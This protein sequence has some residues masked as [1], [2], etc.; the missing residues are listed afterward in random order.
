MESTCG[1]TRGRRGPDNPRGHGPEE[2]ARNP[3][4]QGHMMLVGTALVDRLVV[5]EELSRFERLHFDEAK[6]PLVF[7]FPEEPVTRP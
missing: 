3:Q 1:A 5:K 2:L 4:A 6:G 7:E